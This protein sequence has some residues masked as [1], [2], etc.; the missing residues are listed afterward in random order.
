MESV[1]IPIPPMTL[2]RQVGPTDLETFDNPT[3]KAIFPE[4]PIELYEAVFDFGCGCGRVARQLLQ[5]EP[6]PRRYVGIDVH[7]GML[8]WCTE[9]LSPIDPNFHFLHHDVY[10]PTYAPGNSYRLAEP[11]PVK[12]GEF[13]LVVAASVFT[14]LLKQQAEYYLYEVAR[15]LRPQGIAFTSWFFFDKDSFPFVR[16]GPHC[17]YV[18]EI[19]PTQAVIC[20]RRWFIDTVRR[21]GLC[22]RLTVPPPVAGHQWEVLLEKRTAA[23]VDQFPLGEDGAEWLCGAT[24]KPRAEPMISQADRERWHVEDAVS[25]VDSEGATAPPQPPVLVGPIAELAAIKR[26]WTW[27]SWRA[28]TKPLRVI[29]RALFHD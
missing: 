21:S 24:R 25:S 5:Q 4:I 14:H 18:D 22:V 15:I 17:L 28:I 13:S 23:A 7:R 3:G 6:R 8:D 16:P 2:R 11:F 1:S 20:D 27:R 10:S 9:N 12:D 29:K 26:S 19:D